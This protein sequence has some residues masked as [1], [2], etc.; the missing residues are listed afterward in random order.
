MGGGA[1]TEIEVKQYSFALNKYVYM[2]DYTDDY[3]CCKEE[4]RIET[5]EKERSLSPSKKSSS[6]S[7]KVTECNDKLV[8]PTNSKTNT[9]VKNKLEY[10]LRDIR[11]NIS[12]TRAKQKLL[13]MIMPIMQ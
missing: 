11:E 9:I 1:S 7:K 10:Y 6:T 2:N 3:R 5:K 13:N 4:Y 8:I 12:D